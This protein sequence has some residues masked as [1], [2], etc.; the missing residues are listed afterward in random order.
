MDQASSTADYK[1]GLKLDHSKF[2]AT[3]KES[4]EVDFLIKAM[5]VNESI[6]VTKT[7]KI[8]YQYVD[9]STKSLTFNQ[10]VPASVTTQKFRLMHMS[11]VASLPA[12]LELGT[13][14]TLDDSRCVI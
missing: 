11:D 14:I 9:C 10:P 8:I 5:M 2:T 3:D 1:V 7:V 4:Y 6:S 12:P 13:L